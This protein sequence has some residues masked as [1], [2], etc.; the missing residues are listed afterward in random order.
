MEV[1]ISQDPNVETSFFL[2]NLFWLKSIQ[3]TLFALAVP[4][5]QILVNKVY[6]KKIVEVGHQ[7]DNNSFKFEDSDSNLWRLIWWTGEMRRLPT[8]GFYSLG[9]TSKCNPPIHAARDEMKHAAG[10][11]MIIMFMSQ[12]SSDKTY[13]AILISS[14]F[15]ASGQQLT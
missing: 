6:R 12:R 15:P 5:H 3:N 10:G 14:F 11:D 9:Y 1:K 2:A 13:F 7:A 8:R 4:S